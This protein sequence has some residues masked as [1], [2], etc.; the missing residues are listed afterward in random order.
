MFISLALV[1]IRGR[2]RVLRV[3]ARARVHM[4]VHTSK[5]YVSVRLCNARVLSERAALCG[6]VKQRQPCKS[7]P[8]CGSPDRFSPPSNPLACTRPPLAPTIR[9][10]RRTVSHNEVVANVTTFVVRLHQFRCTATS[11]SRRS[12]KI[13]AVLSS[14]TFRIKCVMTFRTR[15]GEKIRKREMNQM[16]YACQGEFRSSKTNGG[17]SLHP[18]DVFV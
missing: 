5:M 1:R 15:E 18:F 2:K 16:I 17:I 11:T 6:V 12:R 10:C 14:R 8:E 9:P 13:D 4:R 3:P 7:V